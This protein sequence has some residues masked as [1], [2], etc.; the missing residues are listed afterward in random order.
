MNT[1]NREGRGRKGY[2][3]G[4][5]GVRKIN[6]I[7]K[8][9][10]KIFKRKRLRRI[11]VVKDF[12][13]RGVRVSEVIKVKRRGAAESRAKGGGIRKRP[14]RAINKRAEVMNISETTFSNSTRHS[15]HAGTV[16]DKRRDMLGSFRVRLAVVYLIDDS[17]MRGVE[18]FK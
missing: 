16:L 4:H 5:I 14:I 12:T 7:D 11:K 3:G 1:D 10:T 2:R 6:A 17:H 8:V 18:P 15:D 9:V 13:F